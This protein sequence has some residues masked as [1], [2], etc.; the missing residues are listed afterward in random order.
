MISW[1]H[2]NCNEHDSDRAGQAP[3]ILFITIARQK[4]G[5]LKIHDILLGISLTL[6]VL[7]GDVGDD[8]VVSVNAHT[9]RYM[10]MVSWTL[11][12]LRGFFA[13]SLESTAY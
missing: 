6:R 5:Y 11:K 3:D 1:T 10:R 4:K 12:R 8:Y 13:S 9:L 7:V 2:K